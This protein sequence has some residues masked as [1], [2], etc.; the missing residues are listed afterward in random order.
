MKRSL[1]LALSI[2]SLGCS[3]D[4]VAEE[5]RYKVLYESGVKDVSTR[6]KSLNTILLLA[7]DTN[8]RLAIE[9]ENYLQ[10]LIAK[11]RAF[12]NF[13][14]T[15]TLAPTYLFRERI[16][17]GE[18]D[19]F[20][21]GGDE[22]LDVPLSSRM[23]LF[24]GWGDVASLSRAT[25]TIEQRKQLLLNL[26]ESL[27]LDVAQMY[28]QVLRSERSL[29]VLRGSLALQEERVR[30]SRARLEAGLARPLDVSQNEAQASTTR[31]SILAAESDIARGRETL[32]FLVGYPLQKEMLT[33]EFSS[34]LE[35]PSIEELE[36][37]AKEQRQDLKAVEAAT[38]AAREGVNVAVA[39]YFPSLS[40]DFDYFL[41]RESI[42]TERQ[43]SGLLI[44]NLPVFAAGRI[45]AD[46][47]DAWSRYR[48]ALLNHSYLLRQI[49]QEVRNAHHNLT[50]TRARLGEL[51]TQVATAGQAFQAADQSLRVG[52]ATNLE[53]LTAQNQLLSAELQLAG[54]EY[55]EKIFSLTLLRTLGELSSQLLR[56]E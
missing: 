37:R 35:S 7:N 32:S 27:L 53:R 13:L 12:A 1:L 5:Q 8:E 45:R 48:Q 36:R 51:R 41:S 31:A 56:R 17:G 38:R 54:E 33:D 55:N 21:R 30:E 15:I 43:W 20:Q 6:P 34:A 50:Y 22:Q 10:S 9:G 39:Q 47:R 40:L 25:E 24:Q 16:G 3:V 23:D 44:A 49:S 18:N 46:V 4:H 52:L 2:I 42:P 19:I 26:R 14:P 28:Y 11:R 29:L